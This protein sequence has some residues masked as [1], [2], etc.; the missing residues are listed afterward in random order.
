[1]NL[2]ELFDCYL[3]LCNY[4]QVDNEE[5]FN[6]Y[7]IASFIQPNIEYKDISECTP[8]Q[9]KELIIK[10]K[11][12]PLTEMESLMITKFHFQYLLI[13]QPFAV[14]HKLWGLYLNFGQIKFRNIS[15][16]KGFLEKTISMEDLMDDDSFTYT[17]NGLGLRYE[18]I[19]KMLSWVGMTNSSQYNHVISKDMINDVLSNFEEHRKEIHTIF[20]MRDNCKNEYNPKTVLALINKVFDRWS[21]TC[22]KSDGK[23]KKVNGKVEDASSYIVSKS[24]LTDLDVSACVKPMVKYVS[25]VVHPLLL[26]KS[27]KNII[28]VEELEEIRLRT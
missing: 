6:P 11:T 9:V 16:E 8:T 18:V 12:Y 24:K 20:D 17:N 5:V 1:M 25:D 2:R 22:V 19:K 15:L 23:Q 13:R 7:E 21:Y 14:E 4:K 3:N 26:K 27:H 10:K 28:S